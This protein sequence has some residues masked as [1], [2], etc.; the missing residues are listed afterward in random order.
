M[1]VTDPNQI[2]ICYIEGKYYPR[3]TC[4]VHHKRPRHAG[5]GDENDNLV[6]LCANAHQLVH[7]VSQLMQAGKVGPAS[8]L[9]H[10]SYSSPAQRSRLMEVV[11]EE[12]SSSQAAKEYGS[13]KDHVMV[14]VPIPKAEYHK[15][16]TMVHDYKVNGKRLSIS[17]YVSRVVLS[18]LRR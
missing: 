1:T 18:H 10:S 2:V 5:G 3:A 13:G 4:H 12:M 9:V 17:E 14:E 7:R 6:W 15:L 11:Q 16:K 8:D